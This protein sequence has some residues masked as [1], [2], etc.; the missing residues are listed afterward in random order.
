MLWI[1]SNVR[2]I[3]LLLLKRT[4]RLLK[5]SSAWPRIWLSSVQSA[6]WVYL[7][8]RRMILCQWSFI[9]TSPLPPDF[10]LSHPLSLPLSKPINWR[11]KAGI[12]KSWASPMASPSSSEEPVVNKQHEQSQPTGSASRFSGLGFFFSCSEKSLLVSHSWL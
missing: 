5:E 7:F 1:A 6:L 8:D 10:F 11:W 4:A 12:L 3:Y 2:M 9:F